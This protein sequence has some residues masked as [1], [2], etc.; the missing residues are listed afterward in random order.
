MV[1]QQ[2]ALLTS[3]K[4]VAAYLGKGVRTV[5]RWE[6]RLGMPV[7]RPD[8][9]KSGIIQV[10]REE[11]D[12]WLQSRWSPRV[13]DN[14]GDELVPAEPKVIRID[15]AE[16]RHLRL[17]HRTALDELQQSLRH[18]TAQ[19]EALGNELGRTYEVRV[20]AASAPEAQRKLS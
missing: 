15:L 16:A 11:L 4:E 2:S 5:Q 12:R 6:A 13:T 10:S 8:N 9:S 14:S 18:L 17:K 19:C 1:P 3:W 7:R 20:R